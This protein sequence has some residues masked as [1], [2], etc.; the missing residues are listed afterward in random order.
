MNM[1]VNNFCCL[2]ACKSHKPE[3]DIAIWM[4]RGEKNKLM[5]KYNSKMISDIF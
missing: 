2:N 4:A 5:K 3:Y 1:K